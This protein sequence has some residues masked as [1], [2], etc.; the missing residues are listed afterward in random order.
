M[1]FSGRRSHV[2]ME[3]ESTDILLFNSF[4]KGN[5]DA[6]AQLYAK[7]VED[8]VGYASTKLEYLD[9]AHDIIHDLFVYVWEKR[10]DIYIKHSV[11]A[12]LF[13]LLNKRIINHYRSNSYKAIY[14]DQLKRME[15]QYFLAPDSFV[16]AKEIQH[17]VDRAV[18]SMSDKVREIYLLSREDH[19]TNAEIAK[20]LNLSEQTVKNQLSTA[21]SI[22][23]KV[24]KHGVL[25]MV[26]IPFYLPFK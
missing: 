2:D 19:L 17:M 11:R 3:T 6:F 1:Y 5:D 20:Q 24:V 10:A 16:E 14:A 4:K 8:L 9:E 18:Q 21:M 25:L 12:Y 15:Q 22:I 13:W 7:F 26:S 23:R